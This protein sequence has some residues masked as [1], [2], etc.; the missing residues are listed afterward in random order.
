MAPGPDMIGV[1]AVAGSFV[2][3]VSCT[4]IYFGY[5]AWRVWHET[6]LKRDMVARGYSAQEIIEVIGASG[7]GRE[8]AAPLS[9]VPPAKP[10]K[11]PAYSP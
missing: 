1:I 7:A 5:L 3:A 9:S 4:A 11:Q 2:V 6:A 10:V 8:G